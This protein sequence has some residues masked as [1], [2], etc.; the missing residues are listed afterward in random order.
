MANY[1]ITVNGKSYDVTVEKKGGAAAPK[2]AA[3]GGVSPRGCRSC[4]YPAAGS[5]CSEGCCW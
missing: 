5:G 2:V 1:T 3:A 4:R